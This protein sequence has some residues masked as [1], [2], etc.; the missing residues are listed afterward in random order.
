MN[1]KA[2]VLLILGITCIESNAQEN[3]RKDS[4]NSPHSGR[5]ELGARDTT[6]YSF[7]ENMAK[8]Q[9]GGLWVFSENVA[10]KIPKKFK[11]EISR[12]IIGFIIEKDGTPTR[13]EIIQPSNKPKIQVS[14]EFV[15]KIKEVVESC[16]KWKP[17]IV[18]GKPVRSK[19]T[20][21]IN[22]K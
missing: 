3:L 19:I 13:T 4:V 7:V 16:G 10:K 17:G 11:K 21:P 6:I 20:V 14:Q 2:I 1:I 5:I 15:S 8:Y 12:V 18:N 9:E 22:L